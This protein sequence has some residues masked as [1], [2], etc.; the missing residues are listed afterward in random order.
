MLGVSALAQKNLY[1]GHVDITL[2][3][4]AFSFFLSS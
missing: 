3:K 2:F 4:V 1:T